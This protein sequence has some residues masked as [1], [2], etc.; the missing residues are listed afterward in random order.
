MDPQGLLN[1]LI[2]HSEILQ[3]HKRENM[4]PYDHTMQHRIVSWLFGRIL[5]MSQPKVCSNIW[6]LP[7]MGVPQNG[8]LIMENPINMDDLG[9]PLFS[10][11]S[12]YKSPKVTNLSRGVVTWSTKNGGSCYWLSC[13]V[14]SNVKGRTGPSRANQA[15]C[16]QR[17]FSTTHIGKMVILLMDE[18]PNNH[19]GWLKP[20]K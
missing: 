8:W 6:G 19:L 13:K 16:W 7:N 5:P 12:I 11:T 4:Q 17:F 1:S 3:V 20:Y 18:I 14:S 15:K 2:Q 9:V 10:E